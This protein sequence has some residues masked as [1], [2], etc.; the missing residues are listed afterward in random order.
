VS[1]FDAGGDSLRLVL[2]VER[3]RQASG[4]EVKTLDLFRVGTVQGQADLLASSAA[5]T[6]ARSGASGR[7]RLLGGVRGRGAAEP[8]G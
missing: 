8:R 4:R 3:L 1:F 2:L 7:D 6:A 5:P